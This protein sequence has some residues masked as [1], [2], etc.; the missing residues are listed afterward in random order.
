M[1]SLDGCIKSLDFPC[2]VKALLLLICIYDLEEWRQLTKHTVWASKVT[3]E[4]LLYA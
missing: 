4:L 2:F 3:L 1:P